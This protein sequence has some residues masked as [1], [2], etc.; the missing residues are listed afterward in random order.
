LDGFKLVRVNILAEMNISG[1][2]KKVPAVTALA[3]RSTST[4]KCV[5]YTNTPG[6]VGNVPYR[7]PKLERSTV[8]LASA[9]ASIIATNSLVTIGSTKL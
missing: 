7:K 2:D 8:S 5:A 9:P 3:T 6:A 1:A 4:P